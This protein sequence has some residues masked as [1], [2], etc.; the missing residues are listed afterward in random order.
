MRHRT[1]LQ[2]AAAVAASAFLLAG[3][4]GVVPGITTHAGDLSFAG[5]GSHAKLLGLFQVSILHN[6]V[7]LL[8]GVVGLVLARTM[9]GARAFLAAGGAASLALWVLGVADGGGWIPL[10]TA[11]NWLHLL[12]GVA[13]LALGYVT[14]R[15]APADAAA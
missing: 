7:H 1:A 15:R 8:F 14:A 11:D 9:D 4:L 3:V 13:M 6:L 12:L 10:N 5:R 2:T